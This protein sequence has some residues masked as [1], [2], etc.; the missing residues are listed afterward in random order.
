M[1][2]LSK[3]R[4]LLGKLFSLGLLGGEPVLNDLQLVDG[5]LLSCVARLSPWIQSPAGGEGVPS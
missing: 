3:R 2:F 1:Q 4:D 5:L